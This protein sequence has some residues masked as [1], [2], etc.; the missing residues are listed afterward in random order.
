M[1]YE[2]LTQMMR[3]VA[4]KKK[5]KRKKILAFSFLCEEIS[6]GTCGCLRWMMVQTGDYSVA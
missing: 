2:M 5:K 3:L 4:G 6:L 1:P